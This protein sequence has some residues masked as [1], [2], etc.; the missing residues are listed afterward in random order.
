MAEYKECEAVREALYQVIRLPSS[1]EAWQQVNE[2]IN[3][4]PAADV[5]EV[6]RGH[7][8]KHDFVAFPDNCYTG[9][10]ECSVCGRFLPLMEN[11]CPSCGA[12][13]R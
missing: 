7:W 11:Y 5:R 12:D 8:I 6:V 4:V 2:C 13:M 9:S 3:T 10:V 1:S